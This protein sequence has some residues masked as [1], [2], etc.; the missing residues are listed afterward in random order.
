MRVV[1]KSL[2][3]VALLLVGAGLHGACSL[4]EGFVPKCD[5]S[6]PPDDP[7]AC[8]QVAH[9]DT[10]NG[11][12]VAEAVCCVEIATRDYQVC[13]QSDAVTKYT[14]ACTGAGGGGSTC[15]QI[16]ASTYAKC[17]AGGFQYGTG[18]SGGTGGTGGNGGT[19]GSGG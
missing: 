12:V 14:D 17:M 19:G 6:L 7:K 15:C 8:R 9:C 18:G 3:V 10:G 5:G 2:G 4:G 16:G 13:E 11:G 1:S